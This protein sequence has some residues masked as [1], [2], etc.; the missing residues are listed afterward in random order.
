MTEGCVSPIQHMPLKKKIKKNKQKK[1]KKKKKK[2][3]IE[4]PY[5]REYKRVRT[6]NKSL[7]Q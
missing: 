2:K 7:F 3:K 6:W 4:L 1:K 5:V